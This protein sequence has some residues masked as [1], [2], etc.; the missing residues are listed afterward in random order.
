MNITQSIAIVS[1]V[2]DGDYNA[3]FT[4]DSFDM[5]QWNHCAILMAGDS[6]VATDSTMIV[7]GGATA[8]A[9]TAAITAPFRWTAV[10]TGTTASDVWGAWQTAVASFTLTAASLASGYSLIIEF[11]AS[12]LNISGTQYRY[13]TPVIPASGSAGT[14]N[15]WAILTEPRVQ[16]DILATTV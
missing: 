14:V 11:D 6:S 7:Y 3:G 15:M 5:S 2:R 16:K 8:A 1:L 12:D 13:V 4:A 9:V 10:A